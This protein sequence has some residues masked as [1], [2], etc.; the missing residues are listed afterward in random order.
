MARR[1]SAPA[2]QVEQLE[3]RLTPA[4]SIIPAGEFNWLQYSPT[5]ELG[6]L[7]WN[8]ST[9]EYRARVANTWQDTAVASSGTFTAAQ[10]NSSAAVETASQTAQLV[11]TS[12]GTPHALFLEKQWNGTL[13]KYQTFIQHYARTSAGWQKIETITPSWQSQWGPNNLVAEAGPNN[14]IHLIFTD[15][16]VA[17][18][19]VGNFGTGALYYANNV[20]GWAFSKIA[21]TADLSQDVWFT[22]GRWAPRFLSLAVDSQ[23]N[24]YV[25]YTPKFYIAGAFSTVNSTLMYA[26]NKSGAWASQVV[27]SPLDGTADAGLGASIAISPTGQ[28]AIASYYV[29]RYNTGSPEASQLMYHTLVN[30]S[31][32]HTVVA[33][34]PDGYVAGDGPKFTGFSPQLFFDASGRANIVFSDEAGQHLPV[35]FAN[36]VAG[37]IRLATL[38]GSTWA[39]KTV[40][41]QTDPIHNQLF[42]PVAATY[43]GQTTFAGLVATT[44]VDSNN[45]PIN[46]DF[47]LIDIGAPLG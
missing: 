23:N 21:D 39:L 6:E 10:Y 36:E 11:F 30:G 15:T 9:L 28:V 38:T 14:S 42:Y 34:A 18:T 7:V 4:G 31:W 8:G 45:N 41:H 24:A 1:A 13:G 43:K 20:N 5:G 19:G 16:N 27:M 22:G 3:D 35:S 44:T 2:L 46:T 25:T 40:F 12:D 37:Q 32:T 47:T 33:T 26:T 29:D 17:A